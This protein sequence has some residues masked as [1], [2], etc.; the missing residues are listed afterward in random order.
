VLCG[1]VVICTGHTVHACVDRAGKV[2]K[3]PESLVARLP[4][5]VAP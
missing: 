3:L 4:V 1:E 2:L 5:D